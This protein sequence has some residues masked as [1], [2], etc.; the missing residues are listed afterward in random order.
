[1]MKEYPMRVVEVI[2][3]LADGLTIKEI[4]RS[5]GTT[6]EAVESAWKR[7]RE[8]FGLRSHVDALKL[9]LRNGWVTL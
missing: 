5:W 4:A 8:K 2:V 7:A 1:M 3:G 6:D 9:A